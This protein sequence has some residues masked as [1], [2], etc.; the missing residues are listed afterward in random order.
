GR[1]AVMNNSQQQCEMVGKVVGRNVGRHT[2]PLKVHVMHHSIVAHQNFALRVL[3]WITQLIANSDGFKQLLNRVLT[4]SGIFALSD[5]TMFGSPELSQLTA[6][7]A[8]VMKEPSNDANSL[9]FLDLFFLADTHLWKAARVQCHQLFMGSLLME[10]NSK[11][12]FAIIFAKNY[13]K[14]IGAFIKD[15]HDHT[16]SITSLSVQIFTVPTL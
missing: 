3:G 10:Q 11:R 16:M 5:R 7:L 8:M 1:A 2:Q 14:L 9:S 13:P 4:E 6:V 12:R 15:D